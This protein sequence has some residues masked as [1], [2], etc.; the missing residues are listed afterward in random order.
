MLYHPSPFDGVI[1][2]YV[3]CNTSIPQ[4]H[5]DDGLCFILSTLSPIDVIQSVLSML[6]WT[7]YS[8]EM[9][10]EDALSEFINVDVQITTTT[11]NNVACC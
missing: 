11:D 1:H 7:S 10:S 8:D 4:Y 3:R 2:I 9:V 6:F 5:Q